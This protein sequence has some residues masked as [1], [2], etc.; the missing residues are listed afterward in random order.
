MCLKPVVIYGKFYNC[1][2]CF[3]CKAAVK[4]QVKKIRK[5]KLKDKYLKLDDN[6]NFKVFN[7]VVNG[8]FKR[9]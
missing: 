1:G 6:L 7:E 8:D 3:V 4:K 9:K 5:N 2:E